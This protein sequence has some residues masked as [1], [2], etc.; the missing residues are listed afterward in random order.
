M[1]KYG[2]ACVLGLTLVALF[3]LSSTAQSPIRT[4]SL[5]PTPQAPEERAAQEETM[6]ATLD[7]QVGPS[8]VPRPPINSIELEATKAPKVQPLSLQNG[9]EWFVAIVVLL[10]VSLLGNAFQLYRQGIYGKTIGNGLVSAFNSIAWSLSRCVNKTRELDERLAAKKTD[11]PVLLKEFREFSVDSEFI[12]R[13]LREQL[14]AVAR[15]LRRKEKRWGD[16]EF[17]YTPEEIAKIRRVFTERPV[18]GSETA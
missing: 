1:G 15:N 18:E 11:D 2:F 10:T 8:T 9:K 12:L 6:K 14:V 16:G 7:A 4:E 5:P 13:A 17:G 3:P